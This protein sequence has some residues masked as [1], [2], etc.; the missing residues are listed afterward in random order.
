MLTAGM[1]FFISNA[2]PLDKMRC[3]LLVALCSW[4][5]SQA[6]AA[7]SLRCFWTHTPLH[8]T[9]LGPSRPPSH[10]TLPSAPACLPAPQQ[11][12]PPPTRLL[13]LRLHLSAGPVCRLPHFPHVHAAQG[14]RAHAPGMATLP[15]AAAAVCLLRMSRIKPWPCAVDA[16]ALSSADA[17]STL[18]P[19][20][21]P[22]VSVAACRRSARSRMPSS[23]PTSSTPSAS[24]PTSASRWA[25]LRS[26]SRSRS[27]SRKPGIQS[28]CACRWP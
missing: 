8:P 13:P 21:A 16:A 20:T 2:K 3:G 7:P 17:G 27:C 19:S 14:A 10:A 4:A 18:L 26:R 9:A 24:W 23:S 12:A 28:P 1:F 15:P 5:C 22:A 11:G 6:G 25:A